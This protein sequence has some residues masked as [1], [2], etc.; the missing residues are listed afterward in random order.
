MNQ[1]MKD[2]I[3]AT[4]KGRPLS[5]EHRQHVAE[6]NR[7][8]K[9]KKP[10]M[11]RDRLGKTY[12][13]IYGKNAEQEKLK[14]IKSDNPALLVWREQTLT[15]DRY[16]CQKCGGVATIAHHIHPVKV[17]PESKFDLSNGLAVCISCHL[18][19]HHQLRREG[20]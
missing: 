9:S 20:I 7:R 17:S 4:L 18:R 6:A 16:T 2:R 3:S 19:I 11:T 13:E 5:A 15:R 1:E 12:E 10:W 14:R 8:T